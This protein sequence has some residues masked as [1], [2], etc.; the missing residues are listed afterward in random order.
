MHISLKR[1]YTIY[2]NKIRH[3]AGDFM[4]SIIASV[5]Y[6]FARQ[7]VVFP[8]L[9]FRLSETANGTFLTVIALVSIYGV[10]VANTL[11]NIRLIED[12]RYEEAGLQG[13]FNPLCAFYA[14]GSIVFAL[15][16]WRVFSLPPMTACFLMLY[17][18][19]SI[20]YY[21][22]SV[23]FYK[24]LQFKQLLVC[25]IIASAGYL[26]GTV[27][28]STEQMWPLIFLLGDGLPLLYIIRK[29]HFL[30][31][32]WY[33]TQ[34]FKQTVKKHIGL[35]GSGLLGNLLTYA[36]RMLIYPILGAANVSYYTTAS[37]F[38]KSAALVIT[39]ISGVLL[40]YFS[41]KGQRASRKL[42]MLLNGLCLAC[43]GLFLLGCSI[44]G[45]WVTR[46]LYPTLY[47]EALPYLFLAN[48]GAVLAIASQMAQPMILK[49]CSMRWNF[50]LQVVYGVCYVA[51]A[52]VLLPT[53]RL[54]GF[55]LATIFANIVRLLVM[56]TVGWVK[57]S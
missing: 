50:W 8:V 36:D 43:L 41:Q 12:N 20:F 46:L 29:T 9:A 45:P 40:G 47:E 52:I 37:F 13:D 55:C 49:F 3:L 21:Y 56:Y 10:V 48:L 7:I 18:P 16:L 42:F 53:Y 23:H 35:M 26:I 38:G 44:L 1:L 19:V 28:F 30:R 31:E 54:Y 15:I 33:R 34:L 25:S 14:A 2:Q 57:F 22:G 5:V 39:P 51:S 32:P 11:N 4:F 6:A 17:S 24:E 27:L